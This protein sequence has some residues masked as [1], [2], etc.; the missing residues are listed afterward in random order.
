MIFLWISQG[1]EA[2]SVL[3]LASDAFATYIHYI[4]PDSVTGVEGP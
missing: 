2:V 1:S 4:E 3:P